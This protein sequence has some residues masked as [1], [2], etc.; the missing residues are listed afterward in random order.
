VDLAAAGAGTYSSA[1]DDMAKG[2][3][4][5]VAYPGEAAGNLAALGVGD[6]AHNLIDEKLGCR[7]QQVRCR[8]RRLRRHRRQCG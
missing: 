7:R 8:G 5:Y 6:F 2:V 3:P 4:A 1:Q